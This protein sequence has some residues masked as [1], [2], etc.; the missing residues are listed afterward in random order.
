MLCKSN[1]SHSHNLPFRPNK[2][3]SNLQ[4]CLTN[5]LYYRCRSSRGENLDCMGTVTSPHTMEMNGCNRS[6]QR[7]S[8][9]EN[10]GKIPEQHNGH[11]NHQVNLIVFLSSVG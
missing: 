11:N 10:W 2:I 4:P 9:R 1:V 3:N 5:I 7:N 6:Q 8:N